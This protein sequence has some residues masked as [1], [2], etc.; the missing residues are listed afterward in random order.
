LVW[1]ARLSHTIEAFTGATKY[2]QILKCLLVRI[3]FW[4][5]LQEIQE[6]YHQLRQNS[7]EDVEV[8]RRNKVRCTL[9]FIGTTNEQTPDMIIDRFY[10]L[11]GFPMHLITPELSKPDTNP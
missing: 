4:K 11:Q 6:S 3:S 7:R 1:K 9:P 8:K 10:R 5:W 2:V